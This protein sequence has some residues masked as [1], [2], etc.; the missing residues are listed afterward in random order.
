MGWTLY[1]AAEE[2]VLLW[3][4]L[5]TEGA[6][7]DAQPIGWNALESLRIEAGVPRYGAEL[8][9]SV[10][11]LEAELEHAIDFE[12]GCYIGQEIVARMKYRGSPKSALTRY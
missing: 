5:M 1:T 7:F 9:D 12:K 6:R 3:E 10:I 8:T 11:P 2:L 4:T